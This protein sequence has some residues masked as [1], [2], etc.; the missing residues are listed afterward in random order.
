MKQTETLWQALVLFLVFMVAVGIY[1][2]VAVA[3]QQIRTRERTVAAGTQVQ[4]SAI[5][6]TAPLDGTLVQESEPLT[7]RAVLTQP[8]FRRAELQVDGIVLAAEVNPDPQADSWVVEW[9]WDAVDAGAHELTI[10]AQRPQEDW[11]VSVPLIV[12]VP[13]AGQLLFSSNR[14][15]AYAIYRV[16]TNGSGLTRLTPGPGSAYQPA[17]RGDGEFAFV[18]ETGSTQM[19]IQRMPVSGGEPE[20]LVSG[21][22]PA[23]SPNGAHLAYSASLDGVS[24]V[25]ITTAD[26][27]SPS[28]LTMEPAYGGQPAWSPDGAYLTYAAE[29]EG[30]WDI[31]VKAYDGGE[32][33]RLT[34]HPA[35][36][37]AP[38]WSPD[39]SWLAFVSN[40]GGSHQIYVMR[41]DGTDV[42]PLTDFPQGA[43]SPTWSP[44][45]FWLAYVAYT[46]NATG[47]NARE[48]YF[49]RADGR[50]QT[51][52][53]RNAFDDTEPDWIRDLS[54]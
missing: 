14:N 53:T 9:V 41:A 27:G 25:F 7:V 24:Q 8:G 22:D 42:Q 4:A 6:I 51:R 19:M 50:D 32:L 35:M 21:R 44:D 23:W 46:G 13:P 34:E 38:A 10:R 12:T 48:I 29:R 45:G 36:D 18:A 3:W 31:W 30:N 40:R 26:G 49:M 37:W 54:D 2:M 1:A 28:P 43:E 16:Q 33:R 20:A 11:E 39:G 47:V 5:Q 52:L 15:G 17:S